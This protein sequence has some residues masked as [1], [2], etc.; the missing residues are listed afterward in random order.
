MRAK[1]G[2]AARAW[3]V[4]S[5]AAIAVALSSANPIY[6]AIVAFAAIDVLVTWLPPHRSLRPLAVMA[7]VAAAIAMA[8]NVLAAHA[9]ADVLVRLPD[10]LPIVGGPITLE[11]LAYGGAVGL[12]LVAALLA[13]GPLSLVLAPHEIVDAL[14]NRLDRTGIVIATA[15][16]FVGG[17]RRTFQS[18]A[19][20]ARMR[21]WR[22]RGLRSLN[23]VL[24]PVVLTAIEDSVALAEA[25]ESRAFGSGP[26]T[27]FASQA[28]SRRDSLVV[29]ASV[30]GLAV[31]VAARLT[32]ANLDWY[33]YPTLAL[34]PIDPIAVVACLGLVVP[35]LV[36]PAGSIEPDE[37]ESAAARS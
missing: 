14:P 25:M 32:G 19:D 15:L 23:E 18:V 34:P 9:G 5:L 35:A 16:N 33:P 24:V 28:W 30:G 20:A 11:S 31:F 7:L 21:G 12:G 22:P 37:A 29:G 3:L 6:R 4:W 27:S 2:L 10:R 13:V 26:R 36:G 17:I 1:P 8:M